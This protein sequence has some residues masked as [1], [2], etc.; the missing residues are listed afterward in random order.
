MLKGRRKG[1][2]GGNQNED[3]SLR[4]IWQIFILRTN[5]LV[6]K[7]SEYII[8]FGIALD[9]H[10]MANVCFLKGVTGE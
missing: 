5:S 7:D 2:R 6:L 8:G 3:V 1:K 4:P 9:F 10:R